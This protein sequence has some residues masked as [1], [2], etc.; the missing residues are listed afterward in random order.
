MS[1]IGDPLFIAAEREYRF[2]TLSV[3]YRTDGWR[4][5][6]RTADVL[7]RLRRLLAGLRT[8]PARQPQENPTPSSADVLAHPA[9][10]PGVALSA[11]GETP[12]GADRAD[13][14]LAS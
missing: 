1:I 12:G 3:G 11:R 2:Q 6:S 9:A 8:A 7:G 5:P 14:R 10:A 4:A 13:H